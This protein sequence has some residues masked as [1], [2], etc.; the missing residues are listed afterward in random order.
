M[1]NITHNCVPAGTWNK[2]NSKNPI[3][4]WLIRRFEAKLQALLRSYLP[5]IQSGLDFGCGQGHSTNLLIEVGIPKMDGC[6]M[7]EAVL[8]EARQAAP[9]ASFFVCQAESI[10]MI[11]NRYD[12]VC[13]V[14]VLEHLEDPATTLDAAASLAQKFVLLTVPDEP[15][16]RTMNFMAGKYVREFGNS[17]G[18]IQHWNKR[19]FVSMVSQSLEIITATSSTPW[20]LVLG[21][22][23]KPSSQHGESE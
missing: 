23:R 11:T 12:L 4:N 7:S 8:D 9:K 14:E 10:Q 21:R 3:Q 1:A 13:L 5:E 17:P 16:F 18:H 20:L 2:Y 22:P 6:D 15:L 19:S